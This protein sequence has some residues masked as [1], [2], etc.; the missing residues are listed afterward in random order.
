MNQI[1]LVEIA[2]IIFVLLF[3]AWMILFFQVVRPRLMEWVGKRYNVRVRE[4]TGA[5]DA[6]TYEVVGNAP[7]VKHGAIVLIDFV[8]LLLGTVGACALCSIPAF[9]IGESGLP[10]RLESQLFG[11]GV[12]VVSAQIPPLRDGESKG[13]VII[14]NDSDK[15]MEDCR[16]SVAD[17]QAS[18]GY[19]TGAT[20]YFDF[21]PK[22]LR[23]QPITL[24]AVN[25]IPGTYNIRLS[26]EC[27]NRLKGKVG[28]QV[29]VE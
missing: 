15:P 17:Y 27:S 16:V 28:T 20:D 10:Y 26:V 24:S 23:Y 18:N 29:Y 13:I 4:S 1:G 2:G 11:Q 14:Q 12:S 19:L 8:V 22:E 7:L 25:P 9:L 3:I 5:L 6:G 21:S